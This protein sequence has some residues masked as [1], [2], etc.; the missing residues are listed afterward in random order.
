MA[1][2]QK[3]PFETVPPH[4]EKYARGDDDWNLKTT[5][6]PIDSP[7][8]NSGRGDA[9]VAKTLDSANYMHPVYSDHDSFAIRESRTNGRK[10]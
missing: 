1:K 10:K 8:V 7:K 3:H 5:A 9:N 2:Q 4:Q 6:C